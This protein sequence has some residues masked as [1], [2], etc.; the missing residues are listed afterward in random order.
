VAF[1]KAIH[2]PDRRPAEPEIQAVA[3]RLTAVAGVEAVSVTV[4]GAIDDRL[5]IVS[6]VAVIR[7]DDEILIHAIFVRL[8]DGR[9]DALAVLFGHELGHR[10]AGYASDPEGEARADAFGVILAAKAGFDPWE[11]AVWECAMFKANDRQNR[12]DEVHPPAAHR[13]R[14]LYAAA[15]IATRRNAP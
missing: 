14:V 2:Y 1:T 5:P 13:C 4:W 6:P 10:L 9:K 3:D 11:G 12:L 7:G 15:A 8:Y